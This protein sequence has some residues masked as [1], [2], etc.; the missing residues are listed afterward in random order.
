MFPIYNNNEFLKEVATE[1]KKNK[2]YDYKLGKQNPT[3][4]GIYLLGK[5][6]Y[7]EHLSTVKGQYYWTNSLAIILDKKYWSFYKK[8][9]S[10]SEHFLIPKFGC[11]YFL[12]NPDY[13]A[14]NDKI[15]K[16]NYDNFAIYISEELKQKI[17]TIGGLKWKLPKY[18]KTSKALKQLYD[19]IVMDNNI[20]IGPLF[21]S[22]VAEV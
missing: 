21:Q 16:T 10:M 11:G 20:M 14:T 18:I 6:F 19:I 13:P 2:N 9:D 15:N 3:Y 1:Y 5:S 22:N 12:V 7:I 8:P 4:K 17:K